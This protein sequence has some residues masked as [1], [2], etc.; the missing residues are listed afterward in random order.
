LFLSAKF[1][2]GKHDIPYRAIIRAFRELALDILTESADQVAVWRRRILDA[3]GPNGR[4]IVDMLPEIELIIGPQ[5]GPPE[6]PLGDAEKRLRMVVRQFACAFARPDHPL[7]IFLDDLQWMDAASANLVVDLA[8]DPDTRHVLLIGASRTEGAQGSR[9]R[10][11]STGCALAAP[12]CGRSRSR[13]WRATTLTGSSPT[14]CIV[15]RRRPLRWRG[16]CATRRAAIR[17]SSSTSLPGCIR[18]G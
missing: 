11:L 5:P 15:R 1:E 17:S 16:W 2:R 10:L 6:L 7:T 12:P 9:W 14:P 18:S 3:L 8:T 13:R 4:L